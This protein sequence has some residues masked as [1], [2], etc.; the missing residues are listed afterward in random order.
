VRR[1]LVPT[2]MLVLAVLVLSD[3]ETSAQT[4]GDVDVAIAVSVHGRAASDFNSNDPLRLEPDEK[5][6]FDVEITNEGSAPATVRS[7]VLRGEVLNLTFFSYET[8]IDAEVEP[9][10]TEER[11]VPIELT[12]LDGQATGLIPASLQ[13][14]GPDRD[15]VASEE[16]PVDV[17]GSLWSV[18]GVFGLLVA[19]ITVLLLLGV[20]YRLATRR[21]P[22]NRWS[23]AV[24]FG[25]PGL[26]LGLTLTLTLSAL[27]VLAP[28]PVNSL[29]I[30][31]VS[32]AI[33]FVVGYLTPAPEEEAADLEEEMALR[34]AATTPPHGDSTI[35]LRES[36]PPTRRAVA[37][38]SRPTVARDGA[39][40]PPEA[41][42]EGAPLAPSAGDGDTETGGPDGN[43]TT[44]PAPRPTI[45]REQLPPT[46][47]T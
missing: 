5:I 26:A 13:F 37:L 35:D 42:L 19:A 8:R 3:A 36:T 7:L 20:L 4:D 29:T 18:Y 14:L 2:A 22:A 34:A 10:D 17:Q 6:V 12:G 44:R 41:G 46:D 16:F 47:S 23:R 9:D 45:H 40:P 24:R 25:V 21:L 28:H 43:E 38:A 15:V 1:A 31:L 30:V 39:P 27:G 33:L 32:G 11:S